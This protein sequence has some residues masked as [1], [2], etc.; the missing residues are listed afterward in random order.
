MR[1]RTKRFELRLSDADRVE[2]DELAVLLKVDRAE[3]LRVA[4]AEKLRRVRAKRGYCQR[5]QDAA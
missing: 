4:V 2:L 3:A 1:V 5:G